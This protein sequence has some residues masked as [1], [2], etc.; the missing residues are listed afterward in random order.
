[1]TLKTKSLLYNFLGFALLF[2]IV[3]FVA[4]T[5][6]NLSGFWLPLTAAVAASIL[7]PKFQVIKTHEGEKM[8]MKWLFIKGVKEVK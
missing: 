6:T 4:A 1:M 5:F 8:F 7:A 3:R 2:I